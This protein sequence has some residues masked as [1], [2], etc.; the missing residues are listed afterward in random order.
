MVAIAERFLEAPDREIQ[1]ANKI[2][3][4]IVAQ[5]SLMGASKAYEGAVDLDVDL[6]LLGLQIA[7]I[8]FGKTEE[9]IGILEDGLYYSTYLP[10]RFD[11]KLLEAE[12]NEVRQARNS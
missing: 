9:L 2:V 8:A 7:R 1:V 12:L 10:D 6:L 3:G 5:R 11:K 4:A